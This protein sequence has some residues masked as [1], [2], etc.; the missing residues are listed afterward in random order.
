MHTQVILE[1]DEQDALKFVDSFE[2]K[3]LN[4]SDVSNFKLFSLL[5]CEGGAISF[6]GSCFFKADGLD[7]NPNIDRFFQVSFTLK[8]PK[9][10]VLD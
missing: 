7:C 10:Q 6:G 4:S 2:D 3:Q 5:W 1:P 9:V 8:G